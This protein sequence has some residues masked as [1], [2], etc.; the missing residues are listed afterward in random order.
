MGAQPQVVQS[1]C[2]YLKVSPDDFFFFLLFLLFI[3]MAL[4][5][6]NC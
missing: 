2:L 1:V 3:L 4:Q 6:E 5:F